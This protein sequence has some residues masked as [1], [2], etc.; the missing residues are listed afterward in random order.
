MNVIKYKV[1]TG[2]KVFLFIFG[3]IIISWILVMIALMIHFRYDF[4]P[5]T[6]TNFSS[7]AAFEQTLVD[8]HTYAQTGFADELPESAE[9]IKYYWHRYIQQHSAAYSMCLNEMDY[10]KVAQERLEFYQKEGQGVIEYVYSESTPYYLKDSE[11][12]EGDWLFLNEVMHHPEAKEQYYFLVLNM[13]WTDGGAC[14][15][16]VIMNDEANEMIEFSTIVPRKEPF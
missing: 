16:G 11:L 13:F 14:Y 10:Y 2:L 1:P 15:N 9:D 6:K 8:N 5:V 7:H 4:I 3:A 12:Y